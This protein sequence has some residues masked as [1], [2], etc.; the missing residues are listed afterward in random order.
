MGQATAAISDFPAIPLKP[1]KII[2]CRPGDAA[3]LCIGK[4]ADFKNNAVGIGKS[5]V[6]ESPKFHTIGPTGYDFAALYAQ[7]STV[8]GVGLLVLIS[9]TGGVFFL[10]VENPGR[11]A[12]KKA[13]QRRRC[14]VVH[15]PS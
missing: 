6:V 1:G 12:K 4:A 13:R 9:G 3:S 2:G 14:N 15:A 8:N 5:M 7:N 11:L 10:R